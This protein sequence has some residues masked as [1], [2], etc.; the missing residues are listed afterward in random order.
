[1][2]CRQFYKFSGNRPDG[3]SGFA[4]DRA[5]PEDFIQALVV[6]QSDSSA[7]LLDTMLTYLNR[8]KCMPDQENIISEVISAIWEHPCPAYAKLRQKVKSKAEELSKWKISIALDT[9]Y[10]FQIDTITREIRWYP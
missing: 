3:F 6:Q 5:A 9:S 7:K 4:A 8:Y 10:H 1:M 2:Y